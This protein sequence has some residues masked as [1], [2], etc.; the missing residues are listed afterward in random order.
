M[1]LL[2]RVPRSVLWLIEAS[3]AAVAN[4]RR[5]AEQRGVAGERLLFA[6][7]TSRDEH[8]R[9]HALADLFVDTFHYGAHTTASDALRAGL[10]VLTL[11]GGTF[12]SRV[13]AS[14]DHCV[15]LEALI[16]ATVVEY[17]ELAVA[18]AEDRARL[19]ALRAALAA[20][21]PTTPL[22]D[23]ARFARDL[24]HLYA[25]MLARRRAGLG[26]DDLAPEPAP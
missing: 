19:A 6:P 17:E 21:L 2:Q 3:A 4:L 15:G 18:L 14:L 5:A 7:R 22:F 11:R 9:R 10:P 24:E 13:A 25:R 23:A 20:A 26:P 1:R 16:V 8:L 12:A